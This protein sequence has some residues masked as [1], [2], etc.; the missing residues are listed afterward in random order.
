VDKLEKLFKTIQSSYAPKR[1]LLK[2]NLTR[3][4]FFKY[5]FK[6]RRAI[7][8]WNEEF[9]LIKPGFLGFSLKLHP[10][11][12]LKIDDL[13]VTCVL[14]VGVHLPQLLENGWQNQVVTIKEYNL[15]VCFEDF[16]NKMENIRKDRDLP[17]KRFRILED[18]FFR[19]VSDRKNI[20]HLIAGL[21]KMFSHHKSKLYKSE[22][23]SDAALEKLARFFSESGMS[24]SLYDVIVAYNMVETYR[25][26]HFSDIIVLGFRDVV[27]S[28]FYNCSIDVFVRIVKYLEGLVSDLTRLEVGKKKIEWLKAHIPALKTASPQG[29]I[30][31]Y[32]S[33]GHSWR[34]DSDDALLLILLLVEGIMGNLENA[35]NENWRA[36]DIDEKI[37]T[38]RL[39]STEEMAGILAEARREYDL[40][41][42]KFAVIIPHPI[43]L[44]EYLENKVQDKNIGD[45]NQAYVYKKIDAV[46]TLLRTLAEQMNVLYEKRDTALAKALNYMI[47]TPEKWRGKPV[48]AIY[49]FYID[50]ILASCGYFLEKKLIVELKEESEIDK[51]IAI[52][53]DKIKWT[54][55]SNGIIIKAI[56]SKEWGNTIANE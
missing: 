6:E 43:M 24:P 17:A 38:I 40:A 52:L 47:V 48:A 21:R 35:L 2:K 20:D 55:D 9:G 19:F 51:Q 42:Q 27:S 36:M 30:A 31:F 44:D 29:L 4:G 11:F 14:P 23:D 53:R 22:S 7:L 54:K 5:F 16:C 1:P 28:E 37:V 18:S 3:A 49:T 33:L 32:E 12:K 41:R 45:E 56:A 26:L 25:F 34:T 13:F 10:A 50:L 46:L 39:V 15:A 8:N